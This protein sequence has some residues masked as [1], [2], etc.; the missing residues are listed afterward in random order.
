MKKLI[1][2][3]AIALSL[4]VVGGI[5]FAI[6]GGIIMKKNGGFDISKYASK[7]FTTE[8]EFKDISIDLTTY[9]VTFRKSEDGKVKIDYLEGKKNTCDVKVVDSVLKITEIDDRNFIEKFFSINEKD[10]VIYLPEKEYNSVDIEITTGD[11]KFLTNA[12][13]LFANVK[14][15]TGDV[16]GSLKVK[17]DAII[18]TTTGD[19]ELNDIICKNFSIIATTGDIDLT[20]VIASDNLTLKTTTGDVEF[21][22]CDS[23]NIIITATTGDV[24][25]TLL[26]G[27][28][29]DVQTTTGD[30][31]V[32][33]NSEGGMCNVTVTTGDVK[34]KIV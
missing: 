3:I 13:F 27:K 26:T 34:I 30:E 7:T 8:E 12:N 18:K 25:G 32:P 24:T 6:G 31:I 1:K 21:A 10:L 29:F 5:I 9:D 20:S 2:I 14:L 17:N 4:V 28:I 22:S 23:S 33:P 19:V 15:V 16:E 11:I